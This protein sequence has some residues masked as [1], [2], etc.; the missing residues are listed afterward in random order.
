MPGDDDAD[1]TFNAKNGLRVESVTHQNAS[2]NAIRGAHSLDFTFHGAQNLYGIPERAVD[3]ALQETTSSGEPYRMYN[4]DVFRYELDNRIGLYGSVPLM[5]A[6]DNK[7]R[8]SA[9]L[10][11]NPSEMFVDV[12]KDASASSWWSHWIAETGMV[13][14][15][16]LHGPHP[17][18]LIAR[19]V[20]LTGAPALPQLFSLGYHQCRWNYK[21]EED[22][23]MI[24]DKYDEHDM[25]LDVIWLDIEHTDGKRYFT[26]DEHL[27]PQPV[28]MQKRLTERGR[29]LVTISD[30]HIKRASGYYVHEEATSRGH[31]IKNEHGSDYEGDCWPGRSSWLDFFDSKVREYY[32][33]LFAFDKYKG[34]TD[35]LYTWIDMN[36]PSVFSGPEVTM[37]K[38]A[39]HLSGQEHR[40]VH[41]MYGFYHG[42]AT[43]D[44]LLKRH[45]PANDRPFLLSRSFFAGSQRYVAVWTGDNEA[46]WSHVDKAQPMLLTLGISGIPFVGADVGGFFDDPD[47]EMLVR[48][49]QAGIFYPFF[50]AH[51]HIETKR[52]EPWLFG[53]DSLRRIRNALVLRYRLLPYFYT[54]SHHTSLTGVPLMRP[55]WMEWPLDAQ[56]GTLQDQFMLGSA[57]LVKPITQAG[58]SEA[59]V[60]LPKE[61]NNPWYDWETGVELGRGSGRHVTV[62]SPIE[63]GIPLLQRGGTIVP[64]KYRA[65]RSSAQM[66]HDPYTLHIALDAEG[67]AVGD[68]YIDDGHSFDYRDKGSFLHRMFTVRD[69][70]IITCGNAVEQ[71][72]KILG[73]DILTQNPQPSGDYT[74]DNTVERIV[75]YGYPRR[76]QG[77]LVGQGTNVKIVEGHHQ[78]VKEQSITV[79]QSLSFDYDASTRVLVI[80]RPGNLKV[81]SDWHIEIMNE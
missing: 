41:N 17:K 28:E 7:G 65:R 37:H 23:L 54:L 19:Y 26:W 58:Q 42:M 16:F 76:P 5:W 73:V 51:G 10:V 2:D 70:K 33:G 30:P 9:I 14:F 6:L 80:Q 67:N 43:Y 55:M 69:S 22:V 31:Y 77:V 8:A 21:D 63:R 53:E 68:L 29:K 3:F 48:W 24:N 66:T 18:Q 39:K 4:L 20:Q 60:Y 34:S 45:E 49:Y 74:V 44:G 71:R 62:Q 75:V 56:T 64:T 13:E 11:L 57:L 32:A 72:K 1:L 52:R 59:S 47:P 25:P 40:E 35:A 38:E 27:F 81:A 61:N 15:Y 12:G 46:Q 50:R 78:H 36:E 79:R